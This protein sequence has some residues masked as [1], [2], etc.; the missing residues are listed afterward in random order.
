MGSY[1]ISVNQKN[2]PGRQKKNQNFCSFIFSPTESGWLIDILVNVNT[3]EPLPKL[4]LMELI[5]LKK[6]SAEA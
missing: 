4:T 6:K 3:K 2:A 5:F 1:W